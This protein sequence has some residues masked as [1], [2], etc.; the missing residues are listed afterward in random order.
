MRSHD[1]CQPWEGLEQRAIHHGFRSN[2]DCFCY[3]C[4][5]S[6][7]GIAVLESPGEAANGKKRNCNNVPEQHTA[8]F[9]KLQPLQADNTLQMSLLTTHSHGCQPGT[10]VARKDI[11]M[12]ARSPASTVHGF[13]ALELLVV[14]A[15]TG[16]IAAIAI[17]MTG[18]ALG[19]YRLSG[20][21][22][23]VSNA[24]AVTKMRAAATF[25]RA[26][27]YVDLNGKSFHVETWQKT[28]TPAWVAEGGSNYLNSQNSFGF[29]SVGS[30]PPNT[31]DPIGQAPACLD[32][33]S[34]PIGNTACIVFNSR[35]IPVDSSGAPTTANA[36]YLNDGATVYGSTVSATGMI[37]LWQTL[38]RST[39][40]WVLQ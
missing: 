2:P 17:P 28:G 3:F 10:V 11:V 21:A 29:G 13:S 33:S 16:V 32:S 39:P 22:R 38:L 12:F 18:N 34:N 5:P 6:Y 30:A 1:S 37:R 15:L 23:S 24:I 35:G 27:L 7:E 25:S 4:A 31:Q 20:D 8:A 26:R 36:M 40:T 14:V 19:Y 9:G